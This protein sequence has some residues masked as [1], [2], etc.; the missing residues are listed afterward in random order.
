MT[1]QDNQHGREQIRSHTYIC[2][3]VYMY[4]CMFIVDT[5]L[6]VH[7]CMRRMCKTSRRAGTRTAATY[8]HKYSGCLHA[9]NIQHVSF[10]VIQVLPLPLSPP[11]P[12]SSHSSLDITHPLL[13]T[14]MTNSSEGDNHSDGVD[15]LDGQSR[16]RLLLVEGAAGAASW[17][18][19]GSVSSEYR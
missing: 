16:G 13:R 4:V 8:M 9:Q 6:Y 2:I 3:Y 11:I 18:V 19:Y 12:S 5:F 1:K 14:H 10:Q 15:G 17:N 7:V